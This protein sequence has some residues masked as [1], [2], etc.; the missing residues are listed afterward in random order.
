MDV[1]VATPL[2]AGIAVLLVVLVVSVVLSLRSKPDPDFIESDFEESD[3]ASVA[4]SFSCHSCGNLLPDAFGSMRKRPAP[5]C[6][7][8]VTPSGDLKPYDAV[9][10]TTT[11][12][13]KSKGRSARQAEEA[14]RHYLRRM[15]VW[16]KQR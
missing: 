13:L 10:T 8:C 6:D 5:F 2:T 15:P 1:A 14:A 3:P 9:L 11:Q 4:L 16:S 12:L 7:D